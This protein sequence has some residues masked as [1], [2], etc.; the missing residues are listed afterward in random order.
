[1]HHIKDVTFEFDNRNAIDGVKLP[2]GKGADKKGAV[3][4]LPNIK[5]DTGVDSRSN[6]SIAALAAND[7]F[8]KHYNKELKVSEG[9]LK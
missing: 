6:A 9:K 7:S 5:A 1:M 3:G 4:S 8:N 2:G